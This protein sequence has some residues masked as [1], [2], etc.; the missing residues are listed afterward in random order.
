MRYP[1]LLQKLCNIN[2]AGGFHD[3][4]PVRSAEINFQNRRADRQTACVPVL[5]I[6]FCGQ[7]ELRLVNSLGG[8]Y[9]GFKVW[10]GIK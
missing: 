5:K 7:E 3:R 2:L 6:D 1:R 8:Q 10:E 4:R 9:N